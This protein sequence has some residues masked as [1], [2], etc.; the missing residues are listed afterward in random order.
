MSRP[1]LNSY[2]TQILNVNS[3]NSPASDIGVLFSMNLGFQGNPQTIEQK[4]KL[5]GITTLG[6][7]L[8]LTMSDLLVIGVNDSDATTIL[9]HTK[10]VNV[11]LNLFTQISVWFP[12]DKVERFN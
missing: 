1:S 11:Y 8:K 10:Y 2:Q 12:K 3:N 6:Q 4:L 9:K 7:L 5:Q